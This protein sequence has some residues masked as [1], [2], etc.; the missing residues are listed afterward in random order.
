MVRMGMWTYAELSTGIVISC[1]PVIPK[2]FQH[3]GP[4]LSSALTTR[5]KTTKHS[6]NKSASG[7]PSDKVRPEKFKL[8]SFKTPFPSVI[9]S[10]ENDTDH[11]LYSQQSLPKRDYAVLHEET[12]LSSRELS[13]VPA[14][15]LATTRDDLERGYGRF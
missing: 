7:T 8:P 10:T 3:V 13:Q 15:R 14:A 11:E 6:G 1:L 4:K 12:A 5:S 9:S 2:F